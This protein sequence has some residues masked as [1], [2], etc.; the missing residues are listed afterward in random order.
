M[1]PV[2]ALSGNLTTETLVLL[3][4]KTFTVTC[5]CLYVQNW[6]V[7]LSVLVKISFHVKKWFVKFFIVFSKT[8]YSTC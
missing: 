8:I 5:L 6:P 4:E 1:V 3:V 2:V 7:S